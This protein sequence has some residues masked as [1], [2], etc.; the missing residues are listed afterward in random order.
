MTE[1]TPEMDAQVLRYAG[2]EP[3]R[4][5]AARLGVDAKDVLRRV[6]ELIEETDVL[7]LEM[8]KKKLLMDLQKIAQDALSAATSTVDEY[9]AGLYNASAAAQKEILKQL[10][11]LDRRDNEKVVEL[12][13]LRQ[14]ELLR[15]FDFIVEAGVRDISEVYG[16]DEGDVR[17]VFRGKIVEAAREME[18]E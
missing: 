14:R 13:R 2:L 18:L 15:L 6:N 9:K 5:I 3:P 4:S 7:T 8:Q 16:L 17:G 10:E 11:I 12:N 1:F